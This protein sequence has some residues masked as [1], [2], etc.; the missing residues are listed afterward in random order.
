MNVL[1]LSPPDVGIPQGARL[2]SGGGAGERTVGS[3][4]VPF[5]TVIPCVCGRK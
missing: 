4:T 2:A 1:A 3:A 5:G